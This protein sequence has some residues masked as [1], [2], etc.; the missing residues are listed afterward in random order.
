MLEASNIDIFD[1]NSSSLKAIVE[2]F[3]SLTETAQTTV[4]FTFYSDLLK[5][6]LREGQPS[7]WK[8]SDVETSKL[9]IFEYRKKVEASLGK[10]RSFVKMS[11]KWHS[12]ATFRNAFVKLVE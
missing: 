8:H 6:I 4:I 11:Q 5:F 1:K 12:L 9:I 2:I 10:Y 3:C 7:T